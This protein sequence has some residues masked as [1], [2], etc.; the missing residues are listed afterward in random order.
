[1]ISYV[2]PK[3]MNKYEERKQ[4]IDRYKAGDKVTQIVSE[5]GKSRQWFYTDASALREGRWR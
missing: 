3:M 4:A 5:L 1:M 2:R